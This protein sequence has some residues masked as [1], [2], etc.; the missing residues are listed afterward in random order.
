MILTD[1]SCHDDPH[2]FQLTAFLNN[3]LMRFERPE[4]T[5]PKKTAIINTAT[6]TTAVPESVSFREGQVTFFNSVLTSLKNCLA[7]S[8]FDRIENAIALT[9]HETTAMNHMGFTLS[10]TPYGTWQAMCLC[11]LPKH[12]ELDITN[13]SW[14]MCFPKN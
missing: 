3:A 12:Y 5:I 13:L 7:P 14:T 1:E 10:Q 8:N 6:K 11:R 2:L 9:L 4:S